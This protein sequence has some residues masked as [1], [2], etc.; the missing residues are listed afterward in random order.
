VVASKM[1]RLDDWMQRHMYLCYCL[2]AVG[3]LGM[4]L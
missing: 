1:M 2:L 3:A 4:L